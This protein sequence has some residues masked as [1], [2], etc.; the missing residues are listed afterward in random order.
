MVRE[1]KKMC[2]RDKIEDLQYYNIQLSM[3]NR[4]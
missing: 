1:K 2:A 4:K 3:K